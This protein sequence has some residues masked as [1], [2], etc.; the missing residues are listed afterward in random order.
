MTRLGAVNVHFSLL[1]SLR[2]ASPVQHALLGGLAETGV[3]T[4][5]IDAGLDTGAILLQAR[6]PIDDV[7]DAG[8][9]GARLADLGADLMS[10]R[11]MVSHVQTSLLLLRRD[12]GEL[13]AAPHG[14]RPDHRL[15]RPRAR[16]RPPGSRACPGARGRPPGFAASISRSSRH[17]SMQ[18]PQALPERSGRSPRGWWFRPATA[19]WSSRRSRWPAGVGCG[20]RSSPAATGPSPANGSVEPASACPDQR[21][22]AHRGG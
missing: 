1:P 6:T 10:R 8:S 4:M 2:G 13:G 14:A 20:P 15:V 18:A 11:L 3:T 19:E 7:D 16:D 9:L 21:F 5:Q 22:E 12:A 17:G